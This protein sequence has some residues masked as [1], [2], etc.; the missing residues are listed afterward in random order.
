MA[1]ILIAGCGYVGSRLAELLIERGDVV[2]A[3][4]RSPKSLPDGVRTIFADLTEPLD[5]EL[6]PE[7]LDVV[8][9]A[10]SASGTR[11][12]A[13]YHAIYRS[14]PANVLS[15]LEQHHPDVQRFL[16]TSSS[17]VYGQ[18]DASW[19]DE[20]S[21]TEPQGLGGNYMLQGEAVVNDAFCTSIVIRFSGIY[22]PNRMGWTKSAPA[23]PRY[24]NH[25]HREDC[26]RVLKH[27]MDLP[28]PFPCYIAT[29]CEPYI[30][31]GVTTK[32]SK[33][34]AGNKRCSNKRLLDSGY[35]FVYPTY[36]EGYADE[37]S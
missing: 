8:V 34:N 32:A 18:N 14:G 19:V 37:N 12:E 16:F 31:T 9:Y 36:R 15:W 26:A 5:P 2:Y 11:D 13:V 25:I 35:E 7:S 17:G 23:V 28:D 6:V 29:D 33:R 1:K 21:L 30:R 20:T 27:L 22:G 10:A 4:N 24:T 3:L